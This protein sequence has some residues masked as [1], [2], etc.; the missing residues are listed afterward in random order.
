MKSENIR[1]IAVIAHVDH[2]KTTLVDFMLKQFNAFR[3]NEAEMQQTTILDSNPLERERG[4]T[5]LAKNTAI[6][7]RDYK[8]NIIDTPGH[9][10]F[11]GEVE[12]T[13]NMADGALLIVDALEGPMPQTKF[14]LK[15]ALEMGLKVIV[16]INKIDK[17]LANI[18]DSFEK[19]NDL[20]LELATDAEQLNFPVLYAIGREG[21][22]AVKLEDVQKS[23]TLEAIMNTIVNHI[24]APTVEEG[25]FKMIATALDFD[26]HKGKHVI[27]KIRSGSLEKGQ[28]VVLINARGEKIPAKIENIFINR[29]LKKEEVEK[30]EAGEIVDITGVDNVTIGDT[31]TDPSNPVAL[32]R[33]TIEEPTIK[34]SIFANTSPFAGKEGK[35]S[36]SRQ[37]YERLVKELETNI[38]MKLEVKEDKFI[39]SGRGELHLSVLI[40]TLRREGYEFQVGKPEVITKIVDGVE[41]E[42]V[43]DLIIDVPDEFQ[44]VVSRELGE[45]RA[46]MTNMEADGKGNTR[47]EYKIPSK[48]LLG[49]RN[50]LLTNTKGTAVINTMF[51][52]YEPLTP[53]LKK[54]RNGVLIASESG[55]ALTFGLQN[56]QGRGITF[57]DAGTPIY[58]GMIVGLNSR[59][60]DIEINVAKGKHLTNMRASSSDFTVTLTPPLKMSL[61]QYLDFLEED[62]LLEVTPKNL[63]LRKKY[64]TRLERVRNSR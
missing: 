45:R 4:I 39:V 3:E 42:P 46:N 44:G 12:R 38:S 58:E 30:V 37:V 8:I 64:L 50:I 6:N 27:G 18:K 49:L 21:K 47:F 25:P 40:E 16:I 60:D 19:T 31:I 59:N 53:P 23:T 32:P 2:G 9:A 15:K 10:D 57:I 51:D 17:K 61:E 36:N 1:N 28:S 13:L 5:I 7:Y 20:F 62:E 34:I 22:A 41:M 43:E 48:A 56:A 14:V 63:R 11:S 26:T 24:P 55:V 35:Y 29:G 52:K 33:I 54:I